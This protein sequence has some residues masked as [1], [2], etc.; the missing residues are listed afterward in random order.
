MS[1]RK[2]S[3]GAVGRPGSAPDPETALAEAKE[4]SI[5]VLAECFARDLL[6]VEDFER[7]V[8]IVHAA[9]SMPQLAK[10]VDGIRTGGPAVPQVPERASVEALQ[11]MT[12]DVPAGRVRANDRAIA[13]FGETKR[14]GRWIPARQNTFVAALGT[15]VI[16]LREAMLGPGECR[17][18]AITFMGSVE[19]LVPPGL[20]VQ[21][22]GSAILGSFGE[23]PG[24]P[25]TM[26]ELD[27]PVVRIDGLAV[28]GSVEVHCRRPGES[29]KQAKRR[30]KLEKKEARRARQLAE[31]EARRR[32]R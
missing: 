19:I 16:D 25:S 28:L 8:S 15:A 4:E 20:H 29:K 23:Q 24:D 10:A 14:V 22:A 9:A 12:P 32:L 11:R 18:Q 17:I 2:R 31:R 13:L 3:G 21:C 1:A 30:L 5:D 7:R 26:I 6:T 27:A